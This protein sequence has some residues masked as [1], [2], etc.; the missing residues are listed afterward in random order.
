MIDDL[1]YQLR[2]W[3][4]LDNSGYLVALC[5]CVAVPPSLSQHKMYKCSNL[6]DAGEIG[7]KWRGDQVETWIRIVQ[8]KQLYTRFLVS[9]SE[10]SSSF[11]LSMHGLLFLVEA[12]LGRLD[13]AMHH[14]LSPML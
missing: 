12:H 8:G 3:Q 9:I 11:L 1:H 2:Q 4:G 7:G 14:V 6:D 13:P 10:N 5:W